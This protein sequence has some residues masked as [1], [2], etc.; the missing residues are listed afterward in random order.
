MTSVEQVQ[1]LMSNIGSDLQ[2]EGVLQH[3]DVEWGVAFEEQTILSIEFQEERNCLAFECTL[4]LP[5]T[6][7]RLETL[8][9]LAAFS[10]RGLEDG[11][12]RVTL[13]S[14]NGSLT[15]LLDLAC[16]EIDHVALVSAIENFFDLAR[17]L[18]IE[19]SLTVVE[20]DEES[21]SDESAPTPGLRV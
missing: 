11:G 16:N 17:R 7:Q 4:G 18:R 10:R 6:E 1:D 14:P 9:D 20:S 13:D 21:L 12:Q 15:L 19:Y 3:G 5:P 2:V 8:E